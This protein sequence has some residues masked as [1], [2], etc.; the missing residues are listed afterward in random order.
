MGANRR[1]S[2]SEDLRRVHSWFKGSFHNGAYA[3]RL[4]AMMPALA[5]QALLRTVEIRG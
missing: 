5:G 3:F 4:T 2:R 1:E